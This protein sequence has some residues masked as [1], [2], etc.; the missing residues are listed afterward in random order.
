MAEGLIPFLSTLQYSITPVPRLSRTFGN[1][2][3]T[4]LLVIVAIYY[5]CLP[6]IYLLCEDECRINKGVRFRV[7]GVR[8]Q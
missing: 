4:F 3:I 6:H 5:S 7:S 8:C 1:L 2:K